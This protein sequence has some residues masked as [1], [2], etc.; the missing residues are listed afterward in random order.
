[1]LGRGGFGRLTGCN[2][3]GGGISWAGCCFLVFF[4]RL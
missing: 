4:L 3:C 2:D 1:M